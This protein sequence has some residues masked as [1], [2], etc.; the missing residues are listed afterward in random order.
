MIEELSPGDLVR[1]VPRL[2]RSGSSGLARGVGGRVK[3]RPAVVVSTSSSALTVRPIHR[4]T[5]PLAREGLGRTL[6]GWRE[7]GLRKA[8]VVSH[9]RLRLQAVDVSRPI[10]HL[11]EVDRQRLLTS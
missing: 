8:S 2:A 11:A 9:L 3:V 6:Y 4:D 5:S 1:I 7:A 10:G